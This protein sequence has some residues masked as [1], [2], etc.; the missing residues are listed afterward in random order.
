MNILAL[1]DIANR[2][3]CIYVYIYITRFNVHRLSSI[4]RIRA[5]DFEKHFFNVN[6]DVAPIKK[7]RNSSSLFRNFEKNSN[8]S[9]LAFE[10]RK[11]ERERRKR[12][13]YTQRE[14]TENISVASKYIIPLPSFSYSP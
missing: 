8:G 10:L 11:K 9:R 12:Y 3:V 1:S 5:R 2:T 4:P 6:I 14:V 13:G 7:K